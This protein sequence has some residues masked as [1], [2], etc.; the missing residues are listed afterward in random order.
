MI[1]LEDLKK[2]C[3]LTNGAKLAVFVDPLN[4]TMREFEI[5]QS[6]IREAAFL[7]QLAH[8]SGG[9]NYVSELASGKAYEGRRDLGNDQP[10]DGV[11]Y[12][13]RGLIQITGK[14]NYRSCGA[15]LGLDLVAKPSLLERPQYA[16]RSAGWF[17][18]SRGLNAFADKG[19]FITITRRIN[20]G[21]NG[22]KDRYS[23]Y[24]RAQQ[25]FS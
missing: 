13:G 5:D 18:N 25:A 4:E 16:A 1:T 6:G 21:L 8:E 2:I 19:D 11:K 20:G 9:F 23:Y 17:W 7:A 12:K 3:P 14:N 24:E 22:Y 10:G 15:V